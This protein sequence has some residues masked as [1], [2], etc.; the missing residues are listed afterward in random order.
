MNLMAQIRQMK[1]G[2]FSERSTLD[3]VLDY[4]D[5]AFT[6]PSDRVSAVTVLGLGINTA[7]EKVARMA[8]EEARTHQVVIFHNE[9]LIP[10]YKV[11]VVPDGEL[12][13]TSD[14]RGYIR[15]LAIPLIDLL[16]N[17]DVSYDH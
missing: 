2:L 15:I 8:H 6:D 9:A 5:K 14:T 13:H 11:R 17:T 7:L 12:P 16:E 4:A 1:S 10:Q 3:E